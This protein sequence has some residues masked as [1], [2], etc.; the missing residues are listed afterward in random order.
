M[1]KKIRWNEVKPGMQLLYENWQGTVKLRVNGLCDN[2]AI[3]SMTDF[4][5]RKP[6]LLRLTPDLSLKRLSFWDALRSSS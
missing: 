6:F 5:D 3:M 1:A 2:L 4:P